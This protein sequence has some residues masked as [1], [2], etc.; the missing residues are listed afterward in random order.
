MTSPRDPYEVMSVTTHALGNEFQLHY[1]NGSVGV[2][3]ARP[4]LRAWDAGSEVYSMWDSFTDMQR[5]TL[6]AAYMRSLQEGAQEA[7]IDVYI[8]EEGFRDYA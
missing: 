1:S 5:Y 7:P 3:S 8:S 6:T 2:Y 4:F